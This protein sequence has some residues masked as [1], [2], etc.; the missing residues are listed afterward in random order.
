MS[1]TLIVVA[2]LAVLCPSGIAQEKDSADRAERGRR[3][4]ADTERSSNAARKGY[5]GVKD[6]TEFAKSREHAVFSGPQRGEALPAFKVTGLGGELHEQDYDPV[7][8]AGGNPQILMFLEE[9]VGLRGL[10]LFSRTLSQIQSRSDSDLQFT[11]ILLDDDVAQLRTRLSGRANRYS[12][13]GQLATSPDGRDGPGALGL[14]RTVA[15]TILVAKDGKV[16]HNF[17]FPQPMLYGDAHVLGAIA[18][19]I[20]E[21]RKTLDEWLSEQ[22]GD[23]ARTRMTRSEAAMK[24]EEGR[25]SDSRRESNERSYGRRY[26]LK[27]PA[28][29]SKVQDKVVFSGPQAG[30]ALPPLKV[31]GF[32]GSR[33]AKEYD[34]IEQA[35]GK[36][37]VIMLM[38]NNRVGLRGLFGLVGVIGKVAEKSPVGLQTQVVL[39]SDD[40]QELTGT[41]GIFDRLSQEIHVGV[42]ADG[43]DGPGAYG[44]NRN[45]SMT[46]LIAKDGQVVHNFPFPQSM[47]TPDPH[48]LGAIAEVIGVE[49][50]T[51]AGWLAAGE[52]DGERMR[53]R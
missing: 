12:E 49:R 41:S 47:L 46:I 10:G 40:P 37:Q 18:E 3:Q 20:G 19:A 39:L 38:D 32:S 53:R 48:V 5:N 23:V 13:V 44:L 15:M 11:A 26:Q 14:N 31:S 36:P 51:M 9:G 22:Q 4:A 35:D 24:R 42:S 30:E 33:D 34:V 25:A 1:R 8:H 7:K 17:A 52:G 2:M 27:D 43:R 16:L 6:P 29:F 45:V 21:T 28:E 50:D